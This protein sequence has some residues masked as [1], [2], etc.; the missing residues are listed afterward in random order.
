VIRANSEIY[1]RLNFERSALV[2]EVDAKSRRSVTED[3]SN[4]Q[5]AQARLVSAEGVVEE[6]IVDALTDATW[7]GCQPPSGTN[8][9]DFKTLSRCI[10]ADLRRYCA[11]LCPLL[12]DRVLLNIPHKPAHSRPARL[13]VA[14]CRVSPSPKN[15]AGSSRALSPGRT[16]RN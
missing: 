5:L 7:I 10:A 1:R 12:Q 15:R 6:K 2:L 4:T 9:F 8:N 3:G 14:P 16:R 13:R 11:P